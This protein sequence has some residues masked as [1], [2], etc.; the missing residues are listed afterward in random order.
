MLNNRDRIN[1]RGIIRTGAAA[2]IMVILLA[3]AFISVPDTYAA[4]DKKETKKN[5][6][7]VSLENA[8]PI[9]EVHKINVDGEKYCF[10]VQNNVIITP[11][12]V[13]SMSDNELTEE[14]LR[15]A[16]LYIKTANCT[17]AS[18]KAVSSDGWISKGGSFKLSDSDIKSIRAASPSSGVSVRLH[19]DVGISTEPA[20]EEA[21]LPDEQNQ[22]DQATE[23]PGGE[24][25][26]SS[27][28]DAGD[29]TNPENQADAENP[30]TTENQ[31]MQEDTRKIYTTYTLNS[32]ELLFV[33]VATEEDAEK[34]EAACQPSGS[35]NRGQSGISDSAARDKEDMLP[36]FRT[37]KMT[38]RSG[39]P[40]EETLK[41][42]T[43]VSLT[44]IDPDKH[45]SGDDSSTLLQ[46]FPGGAAGLAYIIGIA[47]AAA[48]AI[49]FVI[50][51][52]SAGDD[53]EE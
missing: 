31:V 17:K 13:S 7:E 15:R 8:V 33:A 42:G 45:F 41:D 48:G 38:D 26:E 19:M 51:R 20:P 5:E 29:Q 4:A 52:R 44:W 10:F 37:V 2:M 23:E 34:E 22:Q 32:P 6:K 3:R 11:Q 27:Q 40:L 39:G 53:E 30:Q 1:K 35:A 16:G 25:Q 43:P 9:R 24:Q 36:E 50:R 28:T 21:A 14:I 46:K 12:E 47:A 18:H 49:I